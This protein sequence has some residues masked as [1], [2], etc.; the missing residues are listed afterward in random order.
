[1]RT[2]NIPVKLKFD[3]KLGDGLVNNHNPGA[4]RDAKVCTHQEC[5]SEESVDSGVH[6]VNHG[7]ISVDTEGH[8]RGASR[9]PVKTKKGASDSLDNTL[10]SFLKKFDGEMKASI[11]KAKKQ[12]S[13]VHQI[14][15]LIF[16]LHF[17]GHLL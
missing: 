9:S 4:S 16:L 17:K 3:D 15:C 10:N 11:Q 8:S 5:D 1:M 12:R 14:F 2:I 13:V 7:D 6:E